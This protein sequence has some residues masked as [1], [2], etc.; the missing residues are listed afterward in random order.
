MNDFLTNLL[1]QLFDKFKLQSP[2]LAAIVIVALVTIIK[3]ADEGTA[4]GLFILPGW[5]AE[6][7]QWV[8][9]I[10]LAIVGS[11]TTRYIAKG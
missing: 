2:K 10:L 9:T 3:F 1:A 7:I 11:R 6:A 5:A 8:S 4:L